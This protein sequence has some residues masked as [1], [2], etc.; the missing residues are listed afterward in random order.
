MTPDPNP[1]LDALFKATDS[2]RNLLPCAY[3]V[4]V[5]PKADAKARWAAFDTIYDFVVESMAKQ[6][7]PLAPNE[8]DKSELTAQQAE[9]CAER[10]MRYQVA[11]NLLVMYYG[12][13][14]E[15]W[16]IMCMEA[17]VLVPGTID[18]E[19]LK[20][21]M[22]GKDQALLYELTT[23]SAQEMR[24]EFELFFLCDSKPVELRR[25]AFR[26]LYTCIAGVW[27]ENSDFARACSPETRQAM[28]V[29]A[30]MC[31]IPRDQWTAEDLQKLHDEMVPIPEPDWD[32]LARDMA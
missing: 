8:F 6:G 22:T 17:D 32:A 28:V 18:P 26:V 4:A 5:D 24:E 7:H 13:P 12:D 23:N 25:E 1:T 21:S 27:R 11:I 20:P 31:H 19:T 10:S 15:N 2:A 3:E 16:T 14:K 30:L 9:A 29:M